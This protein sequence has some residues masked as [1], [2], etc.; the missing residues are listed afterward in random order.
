G[1]ILARRANP[2]DMLQLQQHNIPTYDLVIVDL[3]PFEATVAETDNESEI[4]EKID[5]GGISLIRATAKNF[6]DTLIVSDRN[7]Y[8]D[9][10]Q[11]LE[12]NGAGST[13]A[14]RK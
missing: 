3:Y 14:E 5:I 4:I 6:N 11:I 10:L 8:A 12:S 9:L 13:L 7:Q 1:G 2:T